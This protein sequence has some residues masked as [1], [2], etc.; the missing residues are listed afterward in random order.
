M[1]VYVFASQ[2]KQNKIKKKETKRN[3]TKTFFFTATAYH[4]HVF[5]YFS[6]C[7]FSLF[8]NIDHILSRRYTFY[9]AINIETYIILC[10]IVVAVDVAAAASVIVVLVVVV[11][12]CIK[13]DAF[14]FF[15]SMLAFHFI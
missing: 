6:F 1:F 15:L 12:I 5:A 14:N 8:N 9:V 3:E 4:T 13:F 2:T 11:A 7:G 10:A